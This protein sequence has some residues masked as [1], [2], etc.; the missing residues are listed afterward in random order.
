MPAERDSALLPNPPPPRPAARDAAIAAAM[1]RFDGV[2]DKPAA[3]AP[4]SLHWTRKP[5]FGVLVTAALVAVLGIPAALI[6]L[7]SDDLRPRPQSSVPAPSVTAVRR[8]S[9]AP[10]LPPEAPV[11]RLTE[12][13]SVAPPVH[14]RDVA[15][16]ESRDRQEIGAAASNEEALEEA[17]EPRAMI[18]APVAAPPP[19]PPPAPALAQNRAGQAVADE[20]VVTG[21]LMRAPPVEKSKRARAE[22]GYA[23][24]AP[25]WVLKDRAYAAFLTGLQAA[26]RA[27]D[28]DA[29]IRLVAF[30]LRVN[31]NG[32]SQLYRDA[33]SVRRD[34][35]KI[36]TPRV[37]GAIVSQRFDRLFVRDQGLMIGDGQVWFDHVS[38]S[39]P[40]RIRA[41]NP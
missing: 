30:P 20:L 4:R 37:T 35:G 9:V 29:V 25:D 23:P 16:T 40:V 13:P 38:P 8:T 12:E 19:P 21:S 31:S 36:F 15:V 11:T 27:N 5:Q 41:I 17:P 24:I 14:H 33:D 1:R 32:R 34:Y 39:G 26:V 3:S 6:A 10:T 2:E 7:R 18:A 28:R 22:G